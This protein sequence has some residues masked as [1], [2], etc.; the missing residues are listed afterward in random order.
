MCITSKYLTVVVKAVSGKTPSEW[1]R[2]ETV[3]EIERMLCHTQ[4]SIKEIA[5]ELNFSNISFFGKYFKAYKG[6]SPKH[7]RKAYISN[8]A[9]AISRRESNSG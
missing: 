4:K 9:A 5:S 1:I 8:F 6:I 7:Y 3:K 2:E